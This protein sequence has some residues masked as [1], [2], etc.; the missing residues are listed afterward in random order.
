M[1]LRGLGMLCLHFHPVLELFKSPFVYSLETYIERRMAE[2]QKKSVCGNET[3]E[4][5]L[6]ID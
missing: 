6:K 3:W 5:S 1:D 2:T 4:F